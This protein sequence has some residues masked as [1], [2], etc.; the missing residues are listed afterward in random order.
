MQDWACVLLYVYS[1]SWPVEICCKSMDLLSLK[2]RIYRSNAKFFKPQLGAEV[3]CRPKVYGIWE[4]D[5]ME[6][7]IA[8]VEKGVSIWRAWQLKCIVYLLYIM[9]T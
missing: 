1:A 5:S 7:A 2:Q 4:K 3:P 9:T 6:S 8:A